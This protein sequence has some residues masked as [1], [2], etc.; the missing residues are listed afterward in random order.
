MAWF[1]QAERLRR[2]RQRQDEKL[3]QV[4]KQFE[5]ESYALVAA[6]LNQETFITLNRYM[7]MSLD[8]KE[9]QD[10]NAAMKCFT[11]I[12]LTVQEM[13]QSPLEEDQD[14]AENIQ[15]RIFYEESTHDRVRAVLAGY[16]D[17]GLGYLDFLLLAGG[18][19]ILLRLV[20]AVRTRVRTTMLN[21][22]PSSN[23]L[24]GVLLDV[25]NGD[26]GALYEQ[27]AK[28]HGAVFQIPA[29]LGE[30]RTVLA[31]PR[32]IAHFY[33]KDTFT[34]QN[35]NFIRQFIGRVVRNCTTT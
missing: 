16:K 3:L 27:W 15:N 1:L 22:P 31:D 30:R 25:I 4:T 28:K 7:Q 34:Y 6:V 18:A 35:S 23:L 32:A 5:P 11:Q 13:C 2:E 20:Q 26:S 33:S 21:G 12:L 8:N 14:I 29:P 19:W 17:Q 24:F 9:W 10:L